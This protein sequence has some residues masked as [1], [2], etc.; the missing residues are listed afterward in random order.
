MKKYFN[1][2]ISILLAGIALLF[3]ACADADKVFDDVQANITRGAVLRTLETISSELAI[4]TQ[5]GGVLAGEAFSIVIQEQDQQNGAL[6]SA[7]E[8]FIGYDDNN[9]DDGSSAKAEVMSET[10]PAASFAVDEFGLPRYEYSITAEEM[11]TITGI[12]DAEII[13]GDAYT[14]RLELVLTD[15]RRFTD[16]DNS[17]TIT[18]SFYSSPFLYS[19]TIVCPPITPTPGTWVMVQNDSYGDSWN[20]ASLDVTIDGETTVYAH[21]DGPTTTF[22][23]IV[24]DGTV[25]IQITY[26][27]GSFDEENDY[28]ITSANGLVV[29][30]DGPS[31]VAGTSLFDFCLPL[32]L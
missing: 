3:A 30:E 13:G 17:G 21:E 15:G 24:P 29:L 5:N 18:G 7:V 32:D 9:T 26:V 2:R 22:E 16:K 12:T 23:F 8:V 4:D 14:I 10:I 27:G 19:A 25:E 1:T 11:K 28:T 6:L 20:G 31:P